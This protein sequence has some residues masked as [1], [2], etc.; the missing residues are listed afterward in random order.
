HMRSGGEVRRAGEERGTARENPRELADRPAP[1]RDTGPG[2]A[3]ALSAA[4]PAAGEPGSIAS[5]LDPA[6]LRLAG[7]RSLLEDLLA[8]L[9]LTLVRGRLVIALVVCLLAALALAVAG[10][11]PVAAPPPLPRLARRRPG[12]GVAA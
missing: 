3:A 8:A 10:R 7:V 5:R 9:D 12:P 2:G 4:P 6:R 1:L 11:G